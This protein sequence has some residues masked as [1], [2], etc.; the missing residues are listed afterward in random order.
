MESMGKKLRLSKSDKP[1]V[2]DLKADDILTEPKTISW[3]NLNDITVEELDAHFVQEVVVAQK[4]GTYQGLA[5]WFSCQFPNKVDDRNNIV[6]STSP[7]DT[8][9]HWKQ[10]VVVL[11]NAITVEVG[12]PLAFE[13]NIKRSIKNRRRYNIEF[14]MMDPEKVIHPEPCECYLTKCIIIKKM[15]EQYEKEDIEDK[16]DS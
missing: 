13:L 12:E 1:D 5:L 7:M 6:L 4:A 11:P 15:L 16:S 3:I 9:T 2:I 10:T 8:P 14:T